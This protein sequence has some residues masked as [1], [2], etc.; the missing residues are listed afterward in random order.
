MSVR[1]CGPLYFAAGILSLL[2]SGSACALDPA[3][4]ITQYVRRSWGIE[5]GL[6]QG[7]VS[8]I[9]QTADGYLWFGTQ[10]GLAR[11]DGGRFAVYDTSNTKGL[12]SN[13]VTSLAADGKGNLW[14]GTRGGG[15]STLSRDVFSAYAAADGLSSNRVACLLLDRDDV[16]W[17]GTDDG[18]LGRFQ[19]G[20]F[21][22]LRRREG[23]P[24]DSIRS[25]AEDPGGGIWLGTGGAGLAHYRDG[26]VTACGAKAGLSSE[27]VLSL[28]AGGKGKV[29]V[30]TA[31][32]GLQRYEEGK[33]FSQDAPWKRFGDIIG[34]LCL[35][36]DGNLWVGSELGLGRLSG[37]KMDIFTQRQGLTSN[38]VISL[39]EDREGS[40]WAGT[41][42]GLNQF[43]NGKVTLHTPKEGLGE[44]MAYC[45]AR[46]Q[47]GD[48]WMGTT[49]GLMRFSNGA[50]TA[51]NGKGGPGKNPV[52]V[53]YT[54][55]G[56]LVWAAT[57]SGDLFVLKEEKFAP[58]A[59]A[60]QMKGNFIRCL[61]QDE[62][63]GMWF[64]TNR[65]IYFFRGISPSFYTT[66]EG[67]E[68]RSVTVILKSRDGTLWTG[69]MN[70]GLRRLKD[71]R[72]CAEGP[73]KGLA[74]VS[75]Y[76][77]HEDAEGALWIG[78]RGKGLSR[79]W[80]GVL[81]TCSKRDGLLDDTIFQLI[82]DRSGCL[83]MS[84]NHGIFHVDKKDL[85]AFFCGRLKTIS[86]AVLGSSDGMR[87]SECVGGGSPPGCTDHNGE[88]FFPATK[89]LLEIDPSKI[90]IN[91]FPPPV[92]VESF[93]A[94]GEV[95]P[96]AQLLRVHP[97]TRRI[98]VR[99]SAL[100]FLAPER[101]FF[102]HRLE[103]FDK[104]WV[105]AGSL[106]EATYTNLDPGQYTF[107][108]VACNNDGVWN[109]AGAR[110]SFRLRPFFYQTPYFYAMLAL[111]AAG[112]GFGLHRL[113]L[114]RLKVQYAILKE[115]TRIAR[116]IHDT[117]AQGLSGVVLQ[118]ETAEGAFSLKP[119][120]AKESLG[121]ARDLVKISLDETR[122]A[123]LALRPQSL[124]RDHFPEALCLLGNSMT[125]GTS[126]HLDL[127]ILG[128]P[129]PLPHELEA[130][131]WHIAQEALTN[132]IRHSGCHQIK[133][134]V[135]YWRW[136]LRLTLWD[137]GKGF[138]PATVQA[139]GAGFGLLGMRE[140]AQAR[141]WR[142]RLESSPGAGT[143]VRLDVP[144]WRSLFWKTSG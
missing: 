85:D 34:A 45:V 130:D 107:R 87:N 96:T 103:G 117:V 59:E 71:G 73:E 126:I 63:G 11:Y 112:F 121:R 31:G 133:V 55:A 65:G 15:L 119:E 30:G 102:K 122:R 116:E 143:R 66:G 108:V 144:L 2:W 14:V 80:R 142:L 135:H 35:D 60:R 10:E 128:K 8:S 77:L 72:L 40:L 28:C 88:L 64:G 105:V 129:R 131:L 139:Q 136:R 94:D 101:V 36:K 32:G 140:R 4:T 100:S 43:I 81:S 89:G 47:R 50:F 33:G 41:F 99:Y 9:A 22:V 86:C 106:R 132:A 52:R 61:M 13:F 109:D 93:Y 20:R 29:W 5:D 21:T 18:G 79:L 53:V 12:Q 7:T 54:D 120:K 46:G 39:S 17:I 114:Q 6:P 127:E 56:G 58:S 44:N 110:L 92:H 1:A 69:T 37:E 27:N 95:L 123:I 42:V 111:V 25:L 76:C 67:P 24:S 124:E 70:G 115:R 97:G 84:C 137:D 62:K 75:V 26:R 68:Q 113:R 90:R 138:E 125:T 134:T 57:F 16:L 78:T 38:T 141:R 83:W 74:G 82:E 51:Y 91:P 118:L 98:T 19:D 104:D 48:L 49:A 3:K 23:L